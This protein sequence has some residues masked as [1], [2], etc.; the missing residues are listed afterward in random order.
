MGGWVSEAGSSVCDPN[1]GKETRAKFFELE[2]SSQ[3]G[4]AELLSIIVHADSAGEWQRAIVVRYAR[5]VVCVRRV[6]IAWPRAAEPRAT[7]LKN[8]PSPANV[9]GL[10]PHRCAYTCRYMRARR[11]ARVYK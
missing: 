7:Q 9:R 10:V 6:F 5:I 3:I 2:I 11:Y 4:I 8:I 1:S